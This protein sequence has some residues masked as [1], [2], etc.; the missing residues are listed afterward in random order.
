MCWRPGCRVLAETTSRSVMAG[1]PGKA[2]NE[3][4]C[5]QCVEC[6]DMAKVVFSR[7][8]YR[9]HCEPVC[10]PDGRFCATVFITRSA[11]PAV[12]ASRRFPAERFDRPEE[13]IGQA[14]RWAVQ[15][16]NEQ[17]EQNGD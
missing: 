1:L 10:V 7:G 16:V 4:T 14:T 15:W 11:K 17:H 12:V 3:G 8:Q 13:A 5:V 2:D 9:F 6:G